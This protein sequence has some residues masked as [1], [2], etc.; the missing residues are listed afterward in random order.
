MRLLALVFALAIPASA[1]TDK[2]LSKLSEG[3]DKAESAMVPGDQLLVTL[4]LP[5]DKKTYTTKYRSRYDDPKGGPTRYFGRKTGG[6][7]LLSVQGNDG[8]KYLRFTSAF[9]LEGSAWCRRGV[10]ECVP[11]SEKD[12]AALFEIE[13]AFWAGKAGAL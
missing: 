11:M 3:L 13:L 12:A 2:Q 1:M 5:K 10:G 6:D 7:Y 4:G 8:A 9:A